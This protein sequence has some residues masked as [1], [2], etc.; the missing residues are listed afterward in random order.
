[1]ALPRRC[2]ARGERE[3]ASPA[4]REG[5]ALRPALA[6]EGTDAA[7]AALHRAPP[8][9]REREAR[10]LRGEED[11]WPE[12]RA[13]AEGDARRAARQDPLRGA[14]REPPAENLRALPCPPGAAGPRAVCSR[15]YRLCRAWLQPER[16]SKAQMLDLVL[17]ERLLAA[18]P[19]EVARWVRECGAESS[20]Q[21]VALAE[22]CL[23]SRAEE[24][25]ERPRGGAPGP[26]T[27]LADHH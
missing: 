24:R 14:P 4:S 2:Q 9:V 15:L 20:A 1:M 7:P 26:G 3:A 6:G 16:R 12:P 17:L 13:E 22:G 19:A 27:P 23:L 21:A 5:S 25:K 18:L 10:L 8:E 11:A